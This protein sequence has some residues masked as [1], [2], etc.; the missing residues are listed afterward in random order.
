MNFKARSVY[1]ASSLWKYTV[2][3][4]SH[5]LVVWLHTCT[6][7]T[8]QTHTLTYTLY[9]YVHTIHICTRKSQVDVCSGLL[10]L[11]LHITDG[12]HAWDVVSPHPA[13]TLLF[14]VAKVMSVCVIVLC[15]DSIIASCLHVHVHAQYL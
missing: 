1:L 11:F 6:H 3:L 10:S 12:V 15:P 9:T 13:V 8:T 14:R 7:S 5:R 2:A 4:W